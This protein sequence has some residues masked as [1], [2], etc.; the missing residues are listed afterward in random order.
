M[1]DTAGDS[2]GEFLF[3]AGEVVV[4]ARAGGRPAGSNRRAGS[5]FEAAVLAGDDEVVA[6]AGGGGF[7]AAHDAGVDGEIAGDGDDVVGEGLVDVDFHA[8]AHVE[9]FV[10]FLPRGAGLLLDEAEE[11]RGGE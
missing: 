7:A 6:F 2:F 4:T 11:G 9:D 8:V 10:H 1:G 3:F 5:V